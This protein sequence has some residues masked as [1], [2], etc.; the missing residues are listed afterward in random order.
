MNKRKLSIFP[1]TI[2]K[3]S[4]YMDQK[5]QMF[6]QQLMLLYYIYEIFGNSDLLAGRMD[7]YKFGVS[8][9]F[10]FSVRNVSL[11]KRTNLTQTGI[12]I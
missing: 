7:S 2:L 12:H 4:A 5:G 8:F 11:T 9:F 3:N 6:Q 1:I 10:F